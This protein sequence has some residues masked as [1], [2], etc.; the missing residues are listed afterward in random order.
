MIFANEVPALWD[1]SSAIGRRLMA[2]RM[3]K[4]FTGREDPG[5]TDALLAELPGIFLWALEGWR[6]LRASKGKFTTA[7]SAQCLHEEAL[8]LA[9]PIRVFL[10]ECCDKGHDLI[11]PCDAL[12]QAW[13][14]WGEPRGHAPGN[15]S[16]F[17]QSLRAQIPTLDRVRAKAKD[18]R[19]QR[20]WHYAGVCLVPDARALHNPLAA[21]IDEADDCPPKA[22]DFPYGY[23]ANNGRT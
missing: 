11:Y 7:E 6:R 15:S 4:T 14:N 18:A 19:G 13:Q 23:G 21:R 17:G 10:D 1:D 9:S 8:D 20:P 12:Y 5:L 2:L 22:T 3:T 16:Q